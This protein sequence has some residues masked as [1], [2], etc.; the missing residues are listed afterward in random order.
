MAGPFKP[1]VTRAS[2]IT[3]T[4]KRHNHGG[5]IMKNKQISDPAESVDTLLRHTFKDDVP[6]A[7][8]QQMKRQLSQFREKME[9]AHR[10]APVKSTMSFFNRLTDVIRREVNRWSP[11]AVKQGVMVFASI[12]LLALGSLATFTGSGNDLGHSVSSLSTE[13]FTIKQLRRADS[14]ECS[15]KFMKE[16][17]ETLTYTIHRFP[18]GKYRVQYKDHVRR[19][20]GTLWLPAHETGGKTVDPL[21]K[22]AVQFLSRAGLENQLA[23]KWNLRRY[24]P[25]GTG[26]DDCDWGHFSIAG[27]GGRTRIDFTID[28]CTALPSRIDRTRIDGKEKVTMLA[29][30]KW[31]I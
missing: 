11:G 8:E 26:T 4:I 5:V 19:K 28:M 25:Q 30:F 2:T 21:V 14:M 17:G 18:S 9:T 1:V 6:I 24:K 15:L 27:P 22:P 7:V 31:N 13:A 23:G 20:S 10:Q 16:S 12:V 29:E 3:S